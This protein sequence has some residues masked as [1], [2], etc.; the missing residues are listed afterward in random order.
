[1]V[2]KVLQ[3]FISRR[4]PTKTGQ[5]SSAVNLVLPEGHLAL[6]LAAT[7]AWVMNMVTP[8]SSCFMVVE[9]LFYGCLWFF[10]SPKTGWV[11]WLTGE[12]CPCRNY[13]RTRNRR[14]VEK[15]SEVR[16][17]ISPSPNLPM[18]HHHF[19]D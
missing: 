8:K 16:T 12:I 4:N 2:L 3:I 1:M 18:N 14:N 9:W 13:K 5:V 6:N 19:R 7:S 15:I 17:F 11:P 10:F